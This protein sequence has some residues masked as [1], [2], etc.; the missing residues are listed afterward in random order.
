MSEN[1]ILWL[2]KNCSGN[3]FKLINST[4]SIE[5]T[6]EEVLDRIRLQVNSLEILREKINKKF[7]EDNKVFDDLFIDEKKQG[8]LEERKRNLLNLDCE[9]PK[10]L[11]KNNS[12]EEL[13]F[14]IEK[15]RKELEREKQ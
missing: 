1:F 10:G 7:Y 15:Y 3:D 2:S 4:N 12:K 8:A 6:K 5:I 13:L 9:L 11:I 14:C